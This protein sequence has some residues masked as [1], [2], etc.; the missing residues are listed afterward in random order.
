MLGFCPALM[1]FDLGVL[2]FLAI[3]IL[4]FAFLVRLLVLVSSFWLELF[5]MLMEFSRM[6][7]DELFTRLN[8]DDVRVWMVLLCRRMM[9]MRMLRF[10]ESRKYLGS[11]HEMLRG[12]LESLHGW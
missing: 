2:V 1:D 5:D 7:W 10:V 6:M 11:R 4:I 8:I 3:L 12:L 9:R